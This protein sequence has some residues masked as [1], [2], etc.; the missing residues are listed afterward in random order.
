MTFYS[1]SVINAADQAENA[2]GADIEE[3]QDVVQVEVKDGYV[4]V[5]NLCLDHQQLSEYG[6]FLFALAEKI[7]QLDDRD[8]IVELLD[9]FDLPM[10]R[11]ALVELI[12]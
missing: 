4:K 3:R 11:E 10:P 1:Y 12:N 7:G 5:G 9:G 8:S 6:F 2:A